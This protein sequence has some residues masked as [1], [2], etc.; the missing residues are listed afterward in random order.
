VNRLVNNR[1][2]FKTFNWWRAKFK[3]W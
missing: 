3:T 1:T 2:R